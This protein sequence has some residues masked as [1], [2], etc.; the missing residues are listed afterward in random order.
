MAY[1]GAV[2]WATHPH[3]CFC[4]PSDGISGTCY[5]NQ[6]A[7]TDDAISLVLCSSGERHMFTL[8]FFTLK[9]HTQRCRTEHVIT[10]FIRTDC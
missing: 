8:L 9:T 10:R 5:L 4:V 7:G 1:N 2:R 6:A 3:R